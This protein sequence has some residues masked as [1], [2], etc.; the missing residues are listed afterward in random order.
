M[1]NV[2][3]IAE[4]RGMGYLRNT[5]EYE[6]GDWKILEID[7]LDSPGF[8]L[9]RTPRGEGDGDL[10]TGS[11]LHPRI[12]T[13]KAR[14]ANFTNYR[15]Q[16]EAVT[17]FHDPRSWYSLYITYLGRSVKTSMCRIQNISYP[18]I[19]VYKSP[20]FMVEYFVPDP[21]L[22]NP[23]EKHVNFTSTEALW[24]VTRIYEGRKGKL[25][26]S[27]AKTTNKVAFEYEG[28]DSVGFTT[29]LT[30]SKNL[31]GL[32]IEVNNGSLL[33]LD[34]VIDPKNRYPL[35]AG[36]KIIID[37]HNQRVTYN[38]K[39]VEP[40]V[41]RKIAFNALKISPGTNS[42]AVTQEDESVPFEGVINVKYK[43][44]YLCI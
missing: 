1:K 5:F 33:I 25:P 2:T 42:I 40:A 17:Q 38:G 44:R 16:R 4:R 3:I 35:V 19:N 37:S 14:L 41:L 11:R 20:V 36:A 10:I 43:E 9:F 21:G 39:K 22:Y 32:R 30:L 29:E 7:G 13:I 27:Y 15:D 18:T 12:I 26:F 8:E 28:T 34:K 23:V 6:A 31:N 24:H